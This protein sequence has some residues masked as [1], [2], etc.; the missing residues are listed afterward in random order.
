MLSESN[1]FPCPN[2]NEII[3]SDTSKCKYCN[4]PVDPV[5]AEA[6][7]RLQERINQACNDASTMRN[8]AGF[9]WI[10]FAV[11]FIYALMGR[12]VF[13]GLM[14]AVPVMLINWQL[15]YGS[16]KSNDVDFRT[17]KRNRNI[18]LLLMLPIPIVIVA[19]IMILAAS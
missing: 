16:I 7:I 5:A 17:A 11:Q 18:S 9:M 3:G 13:I 8:L 6:A 4:H 12:L 19:L 1:F 14:I 2:C 10:A 15:K